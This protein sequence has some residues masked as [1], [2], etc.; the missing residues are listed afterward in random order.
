MFEEWI[1]HPNRYAYVLL[2]DHSSY[3]SRIGWW[4]S[5]WIGDELAV[6]MLEGRDDRQVAVVEMVAD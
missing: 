5:G 4:T 1:A 2:R 3:S 6:A